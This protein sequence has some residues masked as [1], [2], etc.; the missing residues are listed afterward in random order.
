MEKKDLKK[1]EKEEE[2]FVNKLQ[3]TY[4]HEYDARVVA[5]EYAT[6]V[7]VTLTMGKAHRP[8]DLDNAKY[9]C[10]KFK[11]RVRA[12]DDL[13]VEHNEDTEDWAITV[14]MRVDAKFNTIEDVNNLAEMGKALV[15]L[16]E[17][18]LTEHDVLDSLDADCEPWFQKDEDDSAQWNVPAGSKEETE[19]EQARKDEEEMAKEPAY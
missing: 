2:K 1:I 15:N 17:G 7:M 18:R 19:D 11:K 6:L 9:I 10:N 13:V 16:T 14:L 5:C 12:L 8:L 3:A 4:K